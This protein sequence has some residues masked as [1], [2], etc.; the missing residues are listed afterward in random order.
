MQRRKPNVRVLSM[1]VLTALLL[2]L[3]PAA[4]LRAAPGD[5]CQVTYILRTQ[6]NVGFTVDFAIRNTGVNVFNGWTLRFTFP[7]N[8]QVTQVWNGS[9]T[10]TGNQVAI[11]NLG[12]NATIP[13]GATLGSPPGFNASYSGTNTAPTN[14]SI[15]NVPCNGQ[16]TTTQGQTTTTQ[17]QTTTTQGQT[18]TTQG[19]TT[20][21]QGQTTTTQQQTTTTQQ[22]TTTTVNTPGTHFENPFAGARG[23]VNPDWAAQVQAEATATGGSLGAAMSRTAGF[24][25]AVW[26]DRIAALT[27]GRGLRGHLDGALALANS[28]GQPVTIIIVVYDLPNRDCAALAS[29]GELLISQNGLNRYR[30][31]YIDPLANIVGDQRYRNNVRIVAII[32]PDSLPNLVTNLGTPACAEANSSGAYV[33]GIR[34]AISKLRPFSNLYLYLDTAHSGWLGWPSNFGPAADRYRDMLNPQNGG[35][36]FNS[37]DGLI[38]NTAN[39]TPTN[40]PF[41]TPTQTVGGQQ[42][43]SSTFY[44]FNPYI[45]EQAFATDMRNAM[46]QRGLPSNI[47]MLI[48]TSRNGWGGAARPSGPGTATNVN[49]FVNQ[50]KIDRRPH[51]GGWCNQNGAGIGARPTAAPAAGIDAFVWVKPPGESDG[52]ASNVPDPTDPN[53]KFDAMCDPNAQNRYNGAFPTNALPGAPHAGRWF[54]AQFRM[55]VQNAFP[56]L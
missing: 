33:N 28:S 48:D 40:E 14:F 55:L 46:I 42:V 44:E 7:G 43:M 30:T 53:K 56:A 26:M 31:E 2:A 32:E 23:Y 51:R 21:T 34:Y 47:G 49:D 18:T 36:G 38:S 54:P 50:S 6:W 17:Q 45:A 1:L 3:I 22:Q 4:A 41:L 29:N 5:A 11:T 27:E 16:P 12:Y 13:V 24:S 39:Y 20:T 19:Q 37:I 15:N 52:V 9:V 10:Q 35:P 25:T 8:Q